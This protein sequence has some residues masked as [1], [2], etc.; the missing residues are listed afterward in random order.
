MLGCCGLFELQFWGL[1]H[2]C[3]EFFHGLVPVNQNFFSGK[4]TY[5]QGWGTYF[6]IGLYTSFAIADLRCIY[7]R[8]EGVSCMQ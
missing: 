2:S 8:G 1:G 6:L 3:G 7:L 5:A 4:G